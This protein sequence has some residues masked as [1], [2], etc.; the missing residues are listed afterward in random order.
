MRSLTV[1]AVQDDTASLFS[2]GRDGGTA[3]RPSPAG[4]PK[5]WDTTVR[6]PRNICVVTAVAGH[7]FSQDRQLEAAVPWLLP[8]I[9]LK[10]RRGELTPKLFTQKRYLL[11]PIRVAK[12]A[13]AAIHFGLQR[14]R[15]TQVYPQ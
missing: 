5:I 10:T 6:V 7:G 12:R 9:R 15:H 14:D 8:P 1:L 4:P 2:F 3:L 13:G 11:L